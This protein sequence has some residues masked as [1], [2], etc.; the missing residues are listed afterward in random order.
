MISLM[1]K[2]VLTA[3]VVSVAFVSVCSAEILA[4]PLGAA[5]NAAFH[6]EMPDDKVGGWTDQGGNDLK[7][8]PSGDVKI[9]GVQFNVLP[10]DAEKACIV[11]GGTPRPY[12]PTNATV[13][14]EAAGEGKFLYL[15]HAG[16]WCPPDGNLLGVMRL[17][18]AD[19]SEEVR[20]VRR[21]RDVMDWAQP[22]SAPNAARAWSE[23]NGNTQVSLFVSKFALKKDAAL[24]SIGLEARESVWMVV[25]MSIGGD[26]TVEPLKRNFKV[27]RKVNAPKLAAPLP[28]Q[29][30]PGAVP[31]NIILVIGDGMGM[32]ALELTSLWAHGDSR[33]LVM[34]QMPVAGL[35]ETYSRS[36][37]VTD[38]A[39]SG[40]AIACGVKVDNS[41]IGV[42]FDGRRLRSVAEAARDMGKSIGIMTTDTLSGAT[43]AVFYAH[44]LQ[45][46]MTPEIVSDAAASEFDIIA[47]NAATRGLFVQN[48]AGE[49]QRNLQAEMEA[50]GYVFTS[51]PAG[52]AA[53]QAGKKVIAQIED[54]HFKDSDTVLG[55][56]TRTAIDRL[57]ANKNGFFL[58]VESAYADSGGH[59]NNADKTVL[60]T[61]QADWAVKEALEYAAK[62]GDTL[63]ISTADHETGS[64]SAIMSA[65]EGA[66]PVLYYSGTSHSSAL[67]PIYAFGPGAE[68]F[69]GEINNVE[70]GRGIGKLWKFEVPMLV[71]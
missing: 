17:S 57:A 38:S 46:G 31:R 16:A 42:T 34:Q 43:P 41:N 9:G 4:V 68:L 71:K 27:Q 44:R 66:E 39:A 35:C 22:M 14:V 51:D 23:Y 50:R 10:A 47:G 19:G 67:V 52:M 11:L 21:G 13:M 8:A 20:E 36:S 2:Y 62:H 69:G 61:V 70:I 5:A 28:A 1:K 24:A 25:A 3:A 40:T 32:G 29:P 15:L 45:R 55:E 12:L 54:K 6:D 30:A 60:G 59:G 58:M 48:G 49:N 26:I 64:L 53:A 56:M 7:V 33:R 63:V 18:Y 65:A 37:S